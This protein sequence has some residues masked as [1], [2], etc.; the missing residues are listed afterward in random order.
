MAVSRIVQ[1]K[2]LYTIPQSVLYRT[3][4]KIN[5]TQLTFGV[6][7]ENNNNHSMREYISNQPYHKALYGNN[8]LQKP[9]GNAELLAKHTKGFNSAIFIS[10][11]KHSILVPSRPIL[12]PMLNDAFIKNKQLIEVK[13]HSQLSL[14]DNDGMHKVLNAIAQDLSNQKVKE[15]VKNR[16]GTY[17][18]KGAKHNNPYTAAVKLIETLGETGLGGVYNKL[19]ATIENIK[20]WENANAWRAGDMPL[21]DSMDLLNSIKVKVG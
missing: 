4:D 14:K 9:I 20:N 1:V 10:G 2:R 18:S 21:M 15:F 7:A 19:E 16:G 3:F 11:K 17:W 6:H 8:K 5:S 12:S 13:L